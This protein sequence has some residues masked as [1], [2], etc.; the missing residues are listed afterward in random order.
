MATH[1][2]V[3]EIIAKMPNKEAQRWH[4]MS[5]WVY[6]DSL[7]VSLDTLDA[8]RVAQHDLDSASPFE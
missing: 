8:M 2:D 6:R 7:H 5:P 4:L 3:D 1:R